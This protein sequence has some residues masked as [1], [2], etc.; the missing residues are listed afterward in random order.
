MHLRDATAEDFTAIV[1]I[2][3]QSLD[4]V[5][6]ID[7]DQLTDL[8]AFSSRTLVADDDGQIAGFV[9]ILGPG[10][11]YESVNYRWF[12]ANQIFTS[13]VD[14]VAIAPTHRRLGVGTLLYD[15]LEQNLPVALEV[16]IDPPNDASL[17]FH[18]SRGYR[19]V[20]RLLQENGKTVVLLVKNAD[21]G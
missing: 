11:T 2:N 12:E 18:A 20:G 7:L 8:V 5:T 1:A 6:P 21:L 4:G 3:Q 9:V 16:Y 17:T 19:E 15:E 14:R 13:Y 10:T